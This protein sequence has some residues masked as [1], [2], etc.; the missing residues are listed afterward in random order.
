MI[1]EYVPDYSTHKFAQA[2]PSFHLASSASHTPSTYAF[3]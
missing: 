1:L 2:K 3:T